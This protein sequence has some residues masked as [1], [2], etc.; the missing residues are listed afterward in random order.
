MFINN[1]RCVRILLRVLQWFIQC[2]YA[3]HTDSK[4][5][6]EALR[7]FH[8]TEYQLV[9]PLEE[10]LIDLLSLPATR[11]QIIDVRAIVLESN[12]LHQILLY[13]SRLENISPREE[14]Y[15][16]ALQTEMG[17][18]KDAAQEKKPP[19][20]AK[21][22]TFWARGTGYGTSQHLQ[23]DEEWQP[24]KFAQ[25]KQQKAHQL[26]QAFSLLTAY[27]STP[28]FIPDADE[29]GSKSQKSKHGILPSE[30]CEVFQSSALVPIMEFHLRNDSVMEIMR[31][32]FLYRAILGFIR[33]LANHLSLV[34]LLLPLPNQ[35]MSILELLEKLH[36]TLQQTMIQ[37]HNPTKEDR[38]HQL[39]ATDVESTLKQIHQT[40][41]RK[42]KRTTGRGSPLVGHAGDRSRVKRKVKSMDRSRELY[43]ET[44]SLLQLSESE[45]MSR[46]STCYGYAN[47][48]ASVSLSKE[49][50][51]RLA[52]EIHSLHSDLPLHWNSSVFLS[53]DPSNI[54]AMQVLITGPAKTPYANGCF[55]F[56][57]FCGPRYPQ[58]PPE[59]NM[60]T[61][62]HGVVRFN[63]NLYKCGKVCLS[64]LGTWKGTQ[65]EQW[66]K[67]T[68][69][70]LQVFVSIQ[71]LIFVEHPYFNEPSYERWIGTPMGWVN[72][73]VYN[74]NIKPETIR[75]AMVEMLRKPPR[76]F[77]DVVRSHFTLKKKE[78]L[79]QISKWEREQV[80]KKSN[81]RLA[82]T[83]LREELDKLPNK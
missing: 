9:S 70:L 28:D 14:F 46:S 5:K 7:D 50:M 30:T 34:S 73:R 45:G 26:A 59:V 16:D 8:L 80:H 38:R 51:S 66:N 6:R 56:D 49:T 61:T 44:L 2:I 37:S 18:V 53:V 82:V 19:K 81:L 4:Q 27:V 63:P 58:S 10:S 20:P 22:K 54:S 78:I 71:A 31:V 48:A 69:T 21:T 42:K 25:I 72:S 47:K 67:D 3:K 74:Q 17:K 40:Q 57:V 62:G 12:L 15:N 52:G 55:L 83:E 23:E 64:L 13:I 39:F 77:E 33:A 65:G 41:K 43:Q 35:K 32:E 36:T 79:K 1:N 75:Y 76:G 29:D 11:P 24:E 60:Q 68:S